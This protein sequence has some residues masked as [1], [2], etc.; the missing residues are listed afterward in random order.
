MSYTIMSEASDV[1]V[2]EVEAVIKI[3]LFGVGRQGNRHCNCK[4]EKRE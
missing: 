1:R 3:N 2:R 4:C